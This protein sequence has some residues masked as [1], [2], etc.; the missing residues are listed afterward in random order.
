MK[1]IIPQLTFCIYILLITISFSTWANQDHN[2]FDIDQALSVDEA[3]EQIKNTLQNQG[4]EIVATINH[5]QNAANVGLSLRPTQ[6]LMFRKPFFDKGIIHRSQTIGIDIPFKILVYEDET[7][8]INIKYNDVGYLIDRHELRVHDC[9][10]HLL[11][12]VMDQFGLNDN[13]IV[14]VPSNQSVADTIAKLRSVLKAAGF[15]IPIEINFGQDSRSLRDTSLLIFG[16]PKVG[17]LLMQNRQEIG[18]DLPQ[19]FL[20]FEDENSQV[21][22]A[23]NN[24]YFIAQRA[25]IQGLDTLLNNIANALKNFATQGANP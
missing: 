12:A 20:V 17:T 3:V 4:I 5:A 22:I 14:T 2:V 23:Y 18:L 19:K 21:N 8:T 24:P 16:N 1:R 13:G 11:D 15:F 9:K 6:V 7:G 10:I 25:G